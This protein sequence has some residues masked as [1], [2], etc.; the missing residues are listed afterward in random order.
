MRRALAQEWPR[1]SPVTL[2][3]KAIPLHQV[4]R[5]ASM[6]LPMWRPWRAEPSP[7]WLAA[8]II[9]PQNQKLA[10]EIAELGLLISEQ[11][12]G[13]SPQARHFPRRNRLI[14]GLAQ[15]VVVVEG[16]AKSGSLITA[17]DALDQGRE[18]MAVPGHPLDARAAGCNM[19]IRD[20]AVLVRG[21]KDV[22]AAVGPQ[23]AARR[24]EISSKIPVAVEPAKATIPEALELSKTILSHLGAAPIAE[25]QLIRDLNLPSQVVSTQL[26]T[27]EMDGKLARERGGMLTLVV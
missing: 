12:I 3:A 11:P 17:R 27:L 10:E 6:P 23:N 1:S 18:V 7:L 22:I 24:D 26:L 9:S 25:D 4:W 13:L 14:S 15:A 5:V 2:A 20:G 16:A 21:S 8:S 19:L